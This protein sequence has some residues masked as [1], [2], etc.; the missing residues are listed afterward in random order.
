MFGFCGIQLDQ[1]ADSADVHVDGAGGHEAAVAP[2]R[3]EN[4]IAT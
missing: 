4:L 2:N 3:I 1:F